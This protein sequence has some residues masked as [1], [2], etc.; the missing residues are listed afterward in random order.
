MQPSKIFIPNLEIGDQ[1]ICKPGFH[2]MSEDIEKYAGQGYKPGRIG[3][4][5]TITETDWNEGNSGRCVFIICE[6]NKS[7]VGVFEKCLKLLPSTA[8]KKITEA[9]REELT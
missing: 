4:V 3:I 2:N 7:R 8:L 1:V 5:V 9:I 6:Q